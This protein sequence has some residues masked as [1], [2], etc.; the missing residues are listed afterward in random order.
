LSS[1]ASG[2]S[3]GRAVV[4]GSEVIRGIEGLGSFCEQALKL[5]SAHKSSMKATP[6]N[7]KRAACLK[8]T[9]RFVFIKPPDTNFD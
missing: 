7:L 5:S 6:R 2:G 4:G 3:V 1:F 8:E 9:I